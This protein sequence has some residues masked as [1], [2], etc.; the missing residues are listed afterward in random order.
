[1]TRSFGDTRS[2]ILFADGVVR[3]FQGIARRAKRK[4]E[5]LNAA[6]RLADLNVPPS[7]RLEKLKGDLK[8]FNS[9]RI[10]D[11]WRVI[12]KWQDGDAYEV[13]IIDYH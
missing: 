9:I 1:M 12:F 10:N 8:Q 11:Q 5:A 13:K 6:S 3:E 2:R 4:L 7:N